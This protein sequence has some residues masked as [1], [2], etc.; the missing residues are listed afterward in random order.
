M[1]KT[2]KINLGAIVSLIILG[3]LVYLNIFDWKVFILFLL[4]TFEFN[5]EFTYD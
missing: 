4:F 2:V 3:I 5:M 1:K